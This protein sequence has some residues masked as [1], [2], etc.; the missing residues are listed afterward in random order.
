MFQSGLFKNLV[1]KWTLLPLAAIAA[2]LLVLLPAAGS[3]A[4]K[5]ATVRQS[6]A[7]AAVVDVV[8]PSFDMAAVNR[9]IGADVLHKAGVS[10]HGVTVA[11]IDTGV[12]PVAG[13]DSESK[14]IVGPDLSFESGVDGLYGRDTY[15]HGTVMASIAAGNGDDFT[16]VAPGA[17]ILSVKVADNTGAV[18]VSQVI[19]AV[20]WVIANR[21]TDGMNVR[22]ISLSYRTDSTQ[23]YEVDPLAAAVERAWRAGIVVVVSAGNDGKAAEQLG[24]PAIDP[25]VIAVAAI[26]NRD[27]DGQISTDFSTKGDHTRTPDVAAPGERVLGLAAKNSRLAQE[28]PDAVIDGRYLRGSGTSQAA[29]VVAGSVA[30]LLEDRPDLTPDQV[31]ALLMLSADDAFDRTMAS[32][33]WQEVYDLLAGNKVK[34]EDR[35]RILEHTSSEWTGSRIGSLKLNKAVGAGYLDIARAV[36]FEAINVEQR[37]ARSDGSGSLEKA[38]GTSHVVL[39]DGSLLVGEVTFTGSS[40]SGSSWSG[41]R[42]SGSSW[43]GSSWSGS[44]WSGSSWSGSS[45]SGSSWSGSSWSASSWSGSSWSGSSWSGSSWSG[46]SWS[47]ST[48]F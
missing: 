31:K 34:N 25:Y 40:W 11:I 2:V 7:A 9:D 36:E 29:A 39:P 1:R 26:S 21:A 45:W 32:S 22:V 48:W 38:R 28:N 6:D 14:V 18:D 43:S 35:R 37:H 33:R 42:W 23:L 44:S 17:Q 19:A 16:G 27:V 24:N 4:P 12:D 8:A 15:G 3:A 20:D 41:S 46:S 13:L 30:L 10:G 47:G 5:K